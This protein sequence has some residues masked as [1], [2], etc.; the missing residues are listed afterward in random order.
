[1]MMNTAVSLTA[2]LFYSFPS[3]FP[4]FSFLFFLQP[5]VAGFFDFFSQRM[6]VPTLSLP[7]FP[8]S[9]LSI[10]AEIIDVPRGTYCRNAPFSLFLLLALSEEHHNRFRKTRVSPPPSFSIRATQKS[11]FPWRDEIYDVPLLPSFPPFFFSISFRVS[12]VEENPMCPAVFFL[13]F[14]FFL[15]LSGERPW[16]LAIGP[17]PPSFFSLF[18]TVPADDGQIHGASSACFLFLPFSPQMLG[19]RDFAT[20]SRSLLFFFFAGAA[21]VVSSHTPRPAFPFFFFRFDQRKDIVS[22]VFGRRCAV[23]TF[24]PLFHLSGH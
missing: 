24:L 23:L 4:L 21:N 11:P 18:L 10:W 16:K 1:M 8:P 9:L 19:T 6:D 7:F 3:F 20:E 17:L 12:N 13:S 22:P 5:V 15:F 2:R 14:F